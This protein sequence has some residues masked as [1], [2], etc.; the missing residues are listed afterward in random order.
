[1]PVDIVTHE[2]DCVSTQSNCGIVTTNDVRHSAIIQAKTCSFHAR[3]C[4]ASL[5]LCPF[6]LFLKTFMFADRWIWHTSR[7]IPLWYS[8]FNGHY[9]YNMKHRCVGRLR[10]QYLCTRALH[11]TLATASDDVAARNGMAD[12]IGQP[13]A[14]RAQHHLLATTLITGLYV[15]A[16]SLTLS[17]I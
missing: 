16:G 4:Y 1:M 12:F 6:T 2:L 5:M 14:A 17:F 11:P 10:S 7:T 8:N 15:P 9:G 13:L 3:W